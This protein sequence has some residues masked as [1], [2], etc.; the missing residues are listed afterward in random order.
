MN[1]SGRLSILH[2]CWEGHPSGQTRVI[3]DLARGQSSSGHR[4]GV[5]CPAG[6]PLEQMVRAAGI[7]AAPL[8]FGRPPATGA[9]LAGIARGRG[10]DLVNAHSSLDRKAVLW[11]RARG[12]LT[13]AV[14]FTRHVRTLTFP[15]RL[16][17]QS[18]QVDRIIAV[19]G[20][21]SR[22]L[23]G[24]GAQ[25]GKIVVV[26]NGLPPGFLAHPPDAVAIAAARKH[27][28]RLPGAPIVGVVSRRKA[29]E[30]LLKAARHIERP[31]NL[32]FIGI[33]EEPDFQR[34]A[35]GLPHHAVTFVPFVADP[36]PYYACLSISALPSRQE[37]LSIAQLESMALGIPF[38]GS[39][40][41]GIPDL[42]TDGVDGLLVA[43]GDARAWARA[44]ERLLSEPELAARLAA[45]A[46]R[47]VLESFTFDR[48]LAR[49]EAVYR[50]AIAVRRQ[51]RSHATA[52]PRSRDGAA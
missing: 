49:T 32:A 48:T 10:V 11:A 7:D 35:A 27:L 21:V 26:P 44:I 29:Q 9:V 22:R 12:G 41:A 33:A 2:A 14:V 42:T 15:P 3:I 8:V 51:S 34:L 52:P 39:R 47:K 17:W 5:A 28:E 4:V 30:V 18:R 19:S 40:Y 45:A 37:G 46:R 23:I 43:H 50:E 38:V 36:R 31:L 25:R 24:R 1:D 20:D 6:S 13:A 16:W